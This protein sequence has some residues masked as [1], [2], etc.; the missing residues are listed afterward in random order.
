MSVVKFDE[1]LKRGNVLLSIKCAFCLQSSSVNLLSKKAA[2]SR[3]H[4]RVRRSG[5]FV[6]NEKVCKNNVQS[7]NIA[8]GS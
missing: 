4:S 2:I 6:I 3:Y 7:L 5:E 8:P 1:K